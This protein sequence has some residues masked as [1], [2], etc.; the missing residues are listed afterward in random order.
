M[1]QKIIFLVLTLSLLASCASP[2]V[3]TPLTTSPISPT[4][5]V[6]DDPEELAQLYI[7]TILDSQEDGESYAP[8]SPEDRDFYLT[9][10]YGIP[11]GSWGGASIYTVGN[12]DAREIAVLCGLDSQQSYAAAGAMET[13]R[14]SR[15]SDFAGYFPQQAA[16]VER[17]AVLKGNL[18]VLLICTDL[19]A[20]RN[21]VEEKLSHLVI[22]PF[23]PEEGSP[24]PYDWT[25]KVND[26]GW[27][28]FDPP[29]K[30]DM[31]PYDTTAI[32][33]AWKTGEEGELSEKDAA[34]LAKCREALDLAIKPGMTDFQKE[35]NLHDWLVQSY[36]G[37]Y[38]RTVHDPMTPMG[39]E[40]NLNPYGLLVRGYGICLAYTTTFQ[41][42][43]DLAGVECITVVGASS[44]SSG[45]HAWNMVKLEGEWYCVDPTWNATYKEGLTEETMWPWQHRYFNVTSDHM[46]QTDHQWDYEHVPEATATRFHWDGTGTPPQ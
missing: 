42:L 44:D 43:M 24:E 16:L 33:E 40:D 37:C 28:L 18:A 30:F 36:Y 10:V 6:L 21:V 29:N 25:S 32:K 35:L 2:A 38:D 3:Q 7:Q 19:E 45:D 17:G 9:Q 31:T 13:Y 46:R 26:K 41:L 27:K 14:Q 5:E 11:E 15:M 23:E 4:P 39:R 8:L 20:A 34:I 22:E 1:R 12:T